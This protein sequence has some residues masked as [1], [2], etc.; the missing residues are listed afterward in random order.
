MKMG[1]VRRWK[2]ERIEVLL[3]D[4]LS[5]FCS[6]ERKKDDVL[7][8]VEFAKREGRDYDVGYEQGEIRWKAW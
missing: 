4:L 6:L 7:E 3:V 2:P 5:W 8:L 1:K